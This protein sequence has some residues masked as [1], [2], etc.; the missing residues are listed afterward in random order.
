MCAW[1]WTIIIT[2]RALTGTQRRQGCDRSTEM[3]LVNRSLV[4]AP[5]TSLSSSNGVSRETGSIK[6]QPRA[7]PCT[8]AIHAAEPAAI[9]KKSLQP[10]G[11]TGLI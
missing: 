2:D 9:D 6:F 5:I 1:N 8:R 7:L 10:L 11:T 3:A 4:V